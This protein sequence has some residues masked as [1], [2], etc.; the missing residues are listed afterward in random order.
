MLKLSFN[1]TLILEKFLSIYKI[2]MSGIA[3]SYGHSCMFNF[4]KRNWQ[5]A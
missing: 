3:E 1:N 4:L 2:S 5:T